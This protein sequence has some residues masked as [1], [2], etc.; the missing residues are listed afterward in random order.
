MKPARTVWSKF[1]TLWTWSLVLYPCSRH[2][3]DGSGCAPRNVLR[4]GLSAYS[5]IWRLF[6]LSVDVRCCNHHIALTASPFSLRSK[7]AYT[8]TRRWCRRE[9][10]LL[11]NA[12]KC[13][14]DHAWDATMAA[15]AAA[16]PACTRANSKS[17][18]RIACCLLDALLD[19]V[20][21]CLC[22]R[23]IE[24]VRAFLRL[25]VCA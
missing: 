24:S 4:F 5:C 21:F 16:E 10:K 18:H 11:R 9:R 7:G 15:I 1:S 3:G 12:A 17:A 14:G 20:R 19:A 25:F 13:T 8:P 23:E 6:F 2:M 22:E